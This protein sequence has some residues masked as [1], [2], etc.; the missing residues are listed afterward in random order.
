MEGAQEPMSISSATNEILAIRDEVAVMGAND[1]EIPNL[2]R[3][4]EKLE[5]GEI[6]PL[7][8]IKAAREIQDRKASY[9]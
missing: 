7:D 1:S 5:K 9:H 2:N 3:I 6:N 8:A 4:I